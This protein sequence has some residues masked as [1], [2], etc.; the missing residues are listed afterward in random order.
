VRTGNARSHDFSLR[1]FKTLGRCPNQFRLFALQK[2]ES[3]RYFK[4]CFTIFETTHL[5]KN[6]ALL[7]LAKA[8]LRLADH[9]VGA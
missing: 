1:R 6:K 2:T 8:S 3:R 7:P 5:L 9:F 4:N